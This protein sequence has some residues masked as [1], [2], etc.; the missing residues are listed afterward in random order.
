MTGE[1]VEVATERLHVHAAV[2]DPLATIHEHDG[3]RGM[4]RGH[5]LLQP[6]HGAQYVGSLCD[7]DQLRALVEQLGQSF[8]H[9][10]SLVVERK[11]A[12]L[13]PP[14][15]ADQLPRNDVGVVLHLRHH[16]V[17]A[18]AESQ[19]A[20]AVGHG[21]HGGRSPR[22]ED[23]LLARGGA[24]KGAYPFAGLLEKFGHTPRKVVHP[25]V[26]VGV[27]LLVQPPFAVDHATRLLAGGRTVEVY[28]RFTVNRP[29]KYREIPPYFFYIQHL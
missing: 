5:D 24:Y 9:Q 25:A 3:S 7:S 20:V 29:G 11:H 8:H 2:H 26:H 19:F 17:V 21:V 13:H 12:D 14:S 10:P 1:D 28:Q 27:L 22:G 16:D 6:R 23:D 18:R 4:C 15:A